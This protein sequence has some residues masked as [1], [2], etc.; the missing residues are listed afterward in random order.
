MA[1]NTT[2]K[3]IGAI[4]AGFALNVVLS[5]GADIAFNA[6]GLFSMENFKANSNVAILIVIIYRFVF[7][8]AG[9]YLT[10]KL[11]PGNPMKHSLLLGITGTV[12]SILATVAMWD[13]AEAR[14]NIPVIVMC[15]PSAY[16]GAKLYLKKQ[17]KIS[18]ASS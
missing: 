5:V 7:S 14:Y 2:L 18:K 8:I 13:T 16:F 1:T 12:L 11:A 15:I 4:L 3:S 10:A 17:H 6:T 9:S